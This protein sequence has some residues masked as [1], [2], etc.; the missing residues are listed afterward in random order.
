MLINKIYNKSIIGAIMTRYI[1]KTIFAII[2][3]YA[4]YSLTFAGA[5]EDMIRKRVKDQN[6]EKFQAHTDV[7]MLQRENLKKIE[8]IE[9][10]SKNFGYTEYKK[11]KKDYLAACILIPQ[12]EIIEAQIQLKKNKEEIDETLKTISNDYFNVTQQMLDECIDKV[13]ELQFSPDFKLN[14]G[15]QKKLTQLR[16]IIRLANLQFDTA[17]GAFLDKRYVS[18]ITLYRGVKS[19]AISILKDLAG[20]DEINKIGDKFK[21]HIVDNRNE[22][23]NEG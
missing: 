3:C 11:L 19:Y 21:I 8:M 6:I 23:Y 5:D 17:Q 20:P 14:P 16:D 22:I 7:Q 9:V 18:S 13:S 10:I 12:K 2:I 4:A 15:K 1:F